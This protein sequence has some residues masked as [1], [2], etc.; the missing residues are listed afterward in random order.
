MFVGEELHR[1]MDALG[2]AALDGQIAAE[3]G[4]AA[5]DDGVEVLAEFFGGPLGVLADVDAGFE[6]DAFLG[7]AG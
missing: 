2:I 7:H 6:N 3:G 1:E 5:E 4:T